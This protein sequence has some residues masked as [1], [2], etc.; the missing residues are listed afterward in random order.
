M[1]AFLV[2]MM[3]LA[4]AGFLA[5]LLVHV[6]ALLGLPSPFG[7]ATWLLHVGI[8]VVWF[9]AVLVSQRLSKNVPQADLWKAVLRGC[10]RWMKTGSYV[11]FAYGIVNSSCS[12][13][14][15]VATQSTTSRWRSSTA[16]SRGT[17]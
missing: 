14:G 10:P 3:W 15:R 11:V 9:P 12:S 5:S 7:P 4:A 6:L 17:G 1:Q 13:R 16:D 2:P 8:F